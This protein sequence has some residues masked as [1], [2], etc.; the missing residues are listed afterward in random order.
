MEQEASGV[1][2]SKTCDGT[3]EDM[4]GQL[5]LVIA[6]IFER[7]SRCFCLVKMSSRR[8]YFSEK[9]LLFWGGIKRKAGSIS[10]EGECIEGRCAPGA[11]WEISTKTTQGGE[12]AKRQQRQQ[13]SLRLTN[14]FS[15]VS[16]G[17]SVFTEGSLFPYAFHAI[18]GVLLVLLSFFSSL[19]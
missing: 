9:V 12:K 19:P 10:C 13:N 16:P 5:P 1:H 8:D 14:F 3:L 2:C 17:L 18:W 15:T 6:Q 7:G 4:P 11:D